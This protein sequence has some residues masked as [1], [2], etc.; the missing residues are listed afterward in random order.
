[1]YILGYEKHIRDLRERYARHLGVETRRVKLPKAIAKAKNRSQADVEKKTGLP[2]CYLS[3]VENGNTVPGIE[4]LEKSGRALEV[5]LYTRKLHNADPDTR[6]RDK[7]YR[8]RAQMFP[9]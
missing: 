3:R 6:A 4:T 1:M 8:R 2:R 9:A 5:P 7:T